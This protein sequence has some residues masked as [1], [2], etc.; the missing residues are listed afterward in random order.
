MF[1]R[2]YGLH[3]AEGD[4][5]FLLEQSQAKTLWTLDIPCPFE[6]SKQPRRCPHALASVLPKAGL[7][8]AHLAPL[9][10]GGAFFIRSLTS[11]QIEA[12]H[13]LCG[14]VMPIAFTMWANRVSDLVDELNLTNIAP[15]ILTGVEPRHYDAIDRFISVPRIRTLIV[16]TRLARPGLTEIEIEPITPEPHL[17]NVGAY[18]LRTNKP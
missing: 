15:L 4:V 14:A 6:V 1:V 11:S 18:M 12:A 2:H 5:P 17:T 10:N 16:E 3:W 9:V 13:L 8:P 7:A